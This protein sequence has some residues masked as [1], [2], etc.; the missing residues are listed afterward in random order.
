MA[1]EVKNFSTPDT[2]RPFKD[3]GKADDVNV[4]GKMVSKAV[5]E[6][7]WKWSNDIKPIA[8]TEWCEVFHLGYI[9][10]GQMKVTTKDGQETE[11]GPGDVVAIPPGHDAE[12][13]GDEPCVM[14]DFGAG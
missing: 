5:F 7:G 6:P 14:L 2:T 8:G 11:V 3:H 4:G 10:S 12:T 13:V 1:V 9:V